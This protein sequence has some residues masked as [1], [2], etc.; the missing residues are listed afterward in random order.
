MWTNKESGKRYVGSAADLNSRLSNYFLPSHLKHTDSYICRALLFH[1]YSTFSLSILGY[2]DI[3]GL[4]LEKSRKKILECEQYYFDLIFSQDES[5]T[6]NILKVAGSSLGYK[7]T[8]ESLTKMSGENHHFFFLGKLILKRLKLGL[9]QLYLVR[10]TQ[11]TVKLIQK[12][13]KL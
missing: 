10:V 11:C 5:N 4:S 3:S 6:Y 8:E 12:K 9:A 13:L 2:I 7:Y 1:G